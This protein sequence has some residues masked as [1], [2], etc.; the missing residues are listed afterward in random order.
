[1][2]F[3]I[4]STYLVY[5]SEKAQEIY[6]KLKA[7]EPTIQKW[8]SNDGKWLTSWEHNLKHSPRSQLLKVLDLL[9]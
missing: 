2:N 6:D 8:D 1:M 5:G 4:Y 9:N 3:L 7:L